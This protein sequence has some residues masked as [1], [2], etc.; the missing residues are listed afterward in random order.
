M[1]PTNVTRATKWF[2][3][4]LKVREEAATKGMQVVISPRATIGGIKLLRAGVSWDTAVRVTL[5]KTMKQTDWEKISGRTAEPADDV[6]KKAYVPP[7]LSPDDK[8][9]YK[10][11]GLTVKSHGKP[12]RSFDYN[13]L[14]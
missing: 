10:K 7:C 3:M 6:P 9:W 5:R 12:R 14:L 2:R 1:W 8:P 13:D 11:P 4:I